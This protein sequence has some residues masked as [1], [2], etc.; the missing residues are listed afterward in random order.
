MLA[1]AVNSQAI[2]QTVGGLN[3]CGELVVIGVS[4]EP[5]PISPV[6]LITPALS[7][8]GHPSGTAADVEDTMNFALLNNIR[9]QIQ[10]CPLEEAAR[11]YADMAEGRAR[12]R[13]VLT[14]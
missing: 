7:V 3:P 11:A 10:E 12:Y 6:Q 13:M 8:V 2:A 5:L 4:G 14:M 1:T 9:A